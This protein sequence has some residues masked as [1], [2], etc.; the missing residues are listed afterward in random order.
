M[1]CLGRK[2]DLKRCNKSTRFLVCK[3]HIFQLLIFL[4]ITIPTL[5]LTYSQ[6]YQSTI[7]P[8]IYK[9]HYFDARLAGALIF[10]PSK[11]SQRQVSPLL[12]IY[13]RQNHLY[14]APV[15]L[16]IYVEITNLKPM[17]SNVFSYNAQALIEYEIN[18]TKKEAICPLINLPLIGN[19][20]LFYINNNDWTKAVKMELPSFEG[21][22][23]NAQLHQGEA[24]FG[25][26]LFEVDREYRELDYTVKGIILNMENNTRELESLQL[27]I[28]EKAKQKGTQITAG[29]INFPGK[30]VDLTKLNLTVT[31]LQDI[32]DVE[33]NNDKTKRG[34][35]QTGKGTGYFSS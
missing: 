28:T 16:A 21:R 13:E 2:K 20:G 27:D 8:L 4:L 6:L 17:L 26:M 11:L 3:E 24:V 33:L 9:K 34:S 23:A 7:K 29:L 12:Y 18:N 1:K 14:A 22:A 32:P 31:P 35:E 10:T 15:S 19:K 25:W 30:L 5:S